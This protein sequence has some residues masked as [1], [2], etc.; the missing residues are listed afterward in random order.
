MKDNKE[1]P[2]SKALPALAE[3]KAEAA[4]PAK[5]KLSYKEKKEL[6][7]LEKEIS[8]LNKEKELITGK[9]HD[10]SINFDE[11]QQLSNRFTKLSENLQ[12][13]EFRWLELSE[14][15]ESAT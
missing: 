11:I 1:L 6:E 3:K 9:L 2:V 12:S 13:K 15:A 14:I 10:S 4:L 8:D 7:I 5:A